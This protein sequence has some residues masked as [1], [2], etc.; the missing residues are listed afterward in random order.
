M[1][2][3]EVR[4]TLEA[5]GWSETRR[6]DTGP[7]EE[8]LVARGFP[9]FACQREFLARFGG[10]R[11]WEPSGYVPER[12]TSPLG[13]LRDLLAVAWRRRREPAPTEHFDVFL[14]LERVSPALLELYIPLTRSALSPIGEIAER[15]AGLGITVGG[16]IYA[17]MEDWLWLAGDSTEDAVENLIC[18]RWVRTMRLGDPPDANP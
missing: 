8:A 10:L 14:A 12:A 4:A 2:S 11:F 15:G 3:P 9:V 6:V 5:A 13:K 17:F 18:G 1:F 7:F 16:S